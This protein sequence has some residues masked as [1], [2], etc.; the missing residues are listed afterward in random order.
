MA[1]C[2]TPL[3]QFICFF[4]TLF[5]KK[6]R[7]VAKLTLTRLLTPIKKEIRIKLDKAR[8]EAQRAFQPRRIAVGHG[9]YRLAE[10]GEAGG[11]RYSVW[12]TKLADLADFGLG[13]SGYFAHL[14]GLIFLSVLM[15]LIN[16]PRMH[17]YESDA[18]R[19]PDS[20]PFPF[21]LYGTA[22]CTA[23]EEVVVVTADGRTQTETR[24]LCP[25][26]KMQGLLGLTTILIAVVFVLIFRLHM[27]AIVTKLDTSKQTA[28]DY[29]VAVHDPDPD[30][31]DPDEWYQ[32][33]RD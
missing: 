26:M 25:Y 29:T 8:R 9:D 20:Q 4:L 33:I 14:R 27:N 13:V 22:V 12:K 23:T 19:L 31:T 7:A 18:Y 10:H 30:A 1:S 6:H 24:N 21:F 17:Y 28:Q 2:L 16:I 3:F 15:T 11:T 32:V 5:S